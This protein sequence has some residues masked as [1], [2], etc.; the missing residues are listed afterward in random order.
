MYIDEYKFAVEKAK[1]GPLI[2]KPLGEFDMTQFIKTKREAIL[3]FC[4]FEPFFVIRGVE[5]NEGTP[6]FNRSDLVNTDWHYDEGEIII[7]ANNFEVNNRGKTEWVSDEVL[8]PAFLSQAWI[9]KNFDERFFTTEKQMEM[10]HDLLRECVRENRESISRMLGVLYVAP[11]KPQEVLGILQHIKWAIGHDI[12]T[13]NWLDQP[14][15]A[16]FLSNTHGFHRGVYNNGQ[17]MPLMR[18]IM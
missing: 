8:I 1:Y 9:M 12:L 15:S 14:K 13:C 18:K 3:R 11:N 7:L 10:F 6:V 2:L 4:K 17:G 5:M 16:L